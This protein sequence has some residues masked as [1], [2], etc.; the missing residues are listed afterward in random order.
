M[1]AFVSGMSRK[2]ADE[3]ITEDFCLE[4]KVAACG[5]ENMYMEIGKMVKEIPNGFFHFVQ[6]HTFLFFVK[7]KKEMVTL[8]AVSS[9]ILS[10][11]DNEKTQQQKILGKACSHI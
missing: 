2:C 10:F 4:S 8:S 5:G 1:C 9:W 3:R 6:L 7:K 11:T